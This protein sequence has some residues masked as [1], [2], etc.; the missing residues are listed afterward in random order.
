MLTPLT[1]EVQS[2]S[3]PF[4]DEEETP[5]DSVKGV[6]K[7]I[8]ADNEQVTAPGASPANFGSLVAA[9]DAVVIVP[10]HAAET[11][12]TT[13]KPTR[14]RFIDSPISLAAHR[15]SRRF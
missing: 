3:F 7:W 14:H 9:A 12:T 10:V 15:D 2:R 1:V 4:T 13:T 6:E 8:F 11:T 5:P